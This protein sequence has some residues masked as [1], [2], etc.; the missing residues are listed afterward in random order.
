M[1]IKDCN[2]LFEYNQIDNYDDEYNQIITSITMSNNITEIIEHGFAGMINLKTIKLSNK[3]T[4]IKERVFYGCQSLEEI[5][6]P[7][8]VTTIEGYAFDGCPKLTEV[9][10]PS[11][12][13]TMGDYVFDD[14]SRTIYCQAASQPSTWSY[15]W[16]NLQENITWGYVKTE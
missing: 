9:Y 2:S 7:S 1:K 4:T 10:I 12:V 11:S 15:Y 3:L 6:I 16:N 14:Y 8:T 5:E 13:I